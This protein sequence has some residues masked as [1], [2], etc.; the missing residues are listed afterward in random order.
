MVSST[1]TAQ[2]SERC[3]DL[4]RA[5]DEHTGAA[6]D[7]RRR[8][9]AEPRLSGEERD[10]TA[11]LMD[12]M[13]FTDGLFPKGG[14][15]LRVGD[16]DGPSIGLR[17]ELDALPV[18]ETT[19]VEWRSHSGAMHACGHDV[20][21]AATVA[22]VRALRDVGAPLPLVVVLQPREE[23]VPSGA[24]DIALSSTFADH[25]IRAFLGAHVQPTLPRGCFSA[26][27][28]PVNAAADQFAIEVRGRPGH[29]AYPHLTADPVVAAADLVGSLQHLVSRQV[30]PTHPTV[31][32]V[33]SISGGNSPNVV[34]ATVRMRGILRT[35]DEHDR[36]RLHRAIE[37]TTRSVTDV[38]GCDSLVEVT[39]GA[40]VL[41]NDKALAASATGWLQRAGLSPAPPL[42]SCGA[43]DFSY[44]CTL[45]P[46][47]MVFVGVG[48]ENG[49]DP[50]LHHPD[51]LPPD[52][53]VGDVARAMLAGYL[54]ARDTVADRAA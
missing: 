48:S 16:P 40:P 38:H 10:T 12:A 44:Y 13:G 52:E 34:P 53:S 20:H 26:S 31:L 30:D 45:V 25:D 3:A 39:L 5:L 19:D 22:L 33:G 1:S 51:F 35:F 49:D 6:V 7:L 24:Q 2:T 42:R 47:L 23:T 36:V 15:V 18:R 27:P 29:A 11:T 41:V 17:A 21:M 32:T 4:F 8:L 37:E 14:A 54:A 50:G 46:S 9:H 43:D 28:G